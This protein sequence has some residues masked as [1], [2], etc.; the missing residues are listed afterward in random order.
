MWLLGDRLKTLD[1]SDGNVIAAADAIGGGIGGVA[2]AP[3][4]PFAGGG[5]G[6]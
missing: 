1:G 4:V 6:D 5:T 2:A 3:I